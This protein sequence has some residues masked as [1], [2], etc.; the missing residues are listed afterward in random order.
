VLAGS[1]AVW[2]RILIA[3]ACIGVGAIA[4]HYLGM[5]GL[6]IEATLTYRAPLIAF[7]TAAALIGSVVALW[8]AQRIDAAWLRAVVA[9]P[10][11]AVSAGLHYT[12]VAAMVVRAR[13]A[14]EAH[15]AGIPE[16]WQAAAIIAAAL[17]VL[18]AALVG[19]A[20]DREATRRRAATAD[21]HV[22]IIPSA[23][24]EDSGVV[25]VMPER[26]RRP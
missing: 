22:V 14:F 4:M 3:S 15:A 7:T 1:K 19:A 26:R 12:D 20:Y 9:F 21:D 2:W 11:G 18:A 8:A 24:Q 5:R 6:E 16:L 25:V 10:L 23:P 17:L 13:P